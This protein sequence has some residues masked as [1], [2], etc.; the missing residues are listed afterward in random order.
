MVLSVTSTITSDRTGALTFEDGGRESVTTAAE[1]RD[2]LPARDRNRP[3]AI[4]AEMTIRVN[5]RVKIYQPIGDLPIDD[6]DLTIDPDRYPSLF[7]ADTDQNPVAR[8]GN[9]VAFLA[10]GPPVLIVVTWDGVSYSVRQD[11]VMG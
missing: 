6:P 2:A 11:R 4:A 5:K 1:S 10:A 9:P 7:W 8:T 3:D